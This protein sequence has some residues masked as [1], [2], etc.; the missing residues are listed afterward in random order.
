M[1]CKPTILL[2]RYGRRKKKVPP[3][4]PYNGRP[5]KKNGRRTAIERAMNGTAR[6]VQIPFNFNFSVSV[7][8]YGR[9]YARA[10]VARVV[11]FT[12][13]ATRGPARAN[14]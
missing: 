5:F 9:V 6:S 7:F 14:K 1:G 12:C 8:W 4:D 10:Y 13:F 11:S 3:F 2:T